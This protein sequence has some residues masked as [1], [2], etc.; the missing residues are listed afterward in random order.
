MMSPRS[1]HHRA[2][3]GPGG[4]E[5]DAGDGCHYAALERP[6]ARENSPVSR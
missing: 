6:A 3:S 4:P 5:L 2:M 1:D